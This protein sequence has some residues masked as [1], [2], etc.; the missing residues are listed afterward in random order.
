MVGRVTLSQPSRGEDPPK[1]SPTT[2]KTQTSSQDGV[3]SRYTFPPHTTKRRTTTNLKT[4]NNQNWTLWKSNNQGVKEE[5]FIQTGTRGGNRQPGRSHTHEKN[6]PGGTTKELNRP[7]N[8]S[9]P[10][11]GNKASKPLSLKTCEDW[12]GWR[13]SQPHRR[14]HW[15][16][17]Q[18][19]RT[20]TN[21]PTRES[22]PE[23]PKSLVS[24]RGSDWKQGKS[25]ASGIVPSWTPPP[26]TASQL[27]DM[28]CPSLVN[29]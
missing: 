24:S 28:G 15:R 25:W 8:S 20:Y 6:K 10:A 23:G 29:T 1:N 3:I 16:D 2:L 27:S 19:P 21:P 12:G 5:T 17:P 18:G 14:V 13:K 9:V 22:A 11:W 7:Y 4:K 26:Q